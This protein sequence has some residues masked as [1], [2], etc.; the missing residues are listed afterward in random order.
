MR[1]KKLNAVAVYL[2][3]EAAWTLE[4]CHR[5]QLQYMEALQLAVS[6]SCSLV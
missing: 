6:L 4:Y 2:P 5:K 1:I 3:R